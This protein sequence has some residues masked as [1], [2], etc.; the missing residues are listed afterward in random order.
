VRLDHRLSRTRKWAARP[1]WW[2]QDTLPRPA[3]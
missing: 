3:G 2:P 1:R